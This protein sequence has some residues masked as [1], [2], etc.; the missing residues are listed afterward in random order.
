MGPFGQ[1]IEV[2]DLESYAGHVSNQDIWIDQSGL[3]HLLWKE[4]AIDLRLRES[5]FPEQ[6]QSHRLI[7][8]TISNG[9]IEQ[10]QVL[11]ATVEGEYGWNPICARFHQLPAGE[12]LVISSLTPNVSVSGL[13]NCIFQFSVVK[14]FEW[15]EV[16][17]IEP[18]TGIF[19]TNTVRGGSKPSGI[20][21]L[22]GM[23][24]REPNTLAYIQIRFDN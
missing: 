17:I 22:V 21:D 3:A 14:E 9:K 8:A 1:W 10:K 6:K 16:P 4:S 2:T 19:L 13:P 20:L 18:I 15:F 23:S 7:Y 11:I 5:F 24:P 12:L